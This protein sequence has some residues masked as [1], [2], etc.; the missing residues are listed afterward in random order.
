MRGLA[1]GVIVAAGIAAAVFLG[2]RHVRPGAAA[3]DGP[4]ILI[5]IDTLRADHLP[6]YGY[7]GVRTP[8]IDGLAATST[9]FEHAY[10]H[11]PQTLPAHT[12][13]LTG[14]LPF[15]T[16]VRD[17]V[18]FTLKDG[19]WTLPR[20]LHERGYATGGFVSAYVLREATKINQGFD[21]YDAN[22]PEASSE[23]PLGQVQRDG[24]L[25]LA[26]AEQWLAG[27]T[28]D[29]VF[30]FVHFYEPHKP[31]TPPARFAQY[32]PYDGE[33]AYADELV[34]RLFDRLRAEQL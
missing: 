12:C 13:I 24:A 22:L 25:T 1:V 26:A 31:Y 8:A 5:S 34:G 28:S 29:R 7:S 2:W 23:R 16:G 14:E 15:Q 18:G 17:N 9:V 21:T 27:R 20:A 33:I 19:Q 4:L 6:V 11:V 30:L 32:A 10:S 3:A